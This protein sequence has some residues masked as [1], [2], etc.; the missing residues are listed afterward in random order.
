MFLFPI[1]LFICIRSSVHCSHYST[2]PLSLSFIDGIVVSPS[3]NVHVWSNVDKSYTLSTIPIL[4][5]GSFGSLSEQK[6]EGIIIN[7]LPHETGDAILIRKNR[8]TL[9]WIRKGQPTE[10]ISFEGSIL[11]RVGYTFDLNQR[12]IAYVTYADR[13]GK[14]I[15]FELFYGGSMFEF[16][17][18]THSIFLTSFVT[19]ENQLVIY[20]NEGIAILNLNGLA[21][22]ERVIFS[23]DNQHPSMIGIKPFSNVFDPPQNSIDAF[24]GAIYK[25]TKEAD[26]PG[27]LMFIGTHSPFYTFYIKGS[28]TIF[29]FYNS[30]AGVEIHFFKDVR[31]ELPSNSIS[32]FIKPELEKQYL[33]WVSRDDRQGDFYL[34]LCIFSKLDR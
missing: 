2:K 8:I 29:C 1:F 22:L 19:K 11:D 21:A 31:W 3:K 25:T 17:T 28:R 7:V 26:V 5:D 4:D 34:N 10:D 33:V 24:L 20:S 14:K 18:E 27:Q 13:D 30:E 16:I 12:P 15:Y 9:S 32:S 23:K 6:F